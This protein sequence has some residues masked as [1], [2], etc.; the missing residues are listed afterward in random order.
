MHTITPHKKEASSPK[1]HI[2]EFE[3]LLAHPFKNP[4]QPFPTNALAVACP[5]GAILKVGVIEYSKGLAIC[6]TFALRIKKQAPLYCKDHHPQ[7]G[8]I[9]SL[10]SSL[11]LEFWPQRGI[12][13]ICIWSV[14]CFLFI[15]PYIYSAS[16]LMDLGALGL[17]LSRE[18]F[19][20]LAF[21][22]N[23]E[24]HLFNGW[25]EEST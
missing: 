10:G 17:A 8:F 2:A 18:A 9:S 14:I 20:Y 7:W 12:Q 3:N 24:N 11:S 15:I 6:L 4:L 16:W 19:T 22:W 25:W 5:L 13:D 21:P 23:N 1:C